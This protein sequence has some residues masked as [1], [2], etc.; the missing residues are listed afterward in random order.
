MKKVWLFAGISAGLVVIVLVLAK[1]SG[2]PEHTTP[3]EKG[4]WN[5]KALGCTSCHSVNGRGGKRAPALTHVATKIQN[6]LNSKEYWDRLEKIKESNSRIYQRHKDTYA[7]L[8]QEQG[9]EKV[10]LWFLTYLKDP[11]FDNPEA[12]MPSYL[13]VPQERLNS[14]VDYLMSLK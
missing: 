3:L 2:E 5:F 14:T 12:K 1:L 10:R 11:K 13:T 6:R 9:K 7:R 8:G 4:A